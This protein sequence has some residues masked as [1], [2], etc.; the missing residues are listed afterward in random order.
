MIR[1]NLNYVKMAEEYETSTINTS[2]TRNEP[3]GKHMDNLARN[4]LEDFNR[5]TPQ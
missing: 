1:S 3:T 5:C 2:G 4:N